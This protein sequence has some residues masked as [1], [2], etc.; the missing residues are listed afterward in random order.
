M[1]RRNTREIAMKLLFQLEVQ[2][3]GKEE[4]IDHILEESELIDK[5]Y[6]QR[7]KYF[8]DNLGK[9]Y[10]DWAISLEARGASK[11]EVFEKL[12]LAFQTDPAQMSIK[13]LAE[14]FEEIT[15]LN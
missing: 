12:E 15:N 3:E 1:G 13:K 5:I 11:K 9:V 6:K 2:K 14:Y 4:Q 8:P 10:S 7:I